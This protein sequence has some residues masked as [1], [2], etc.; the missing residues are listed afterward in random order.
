MVRPLQVASALGDLAAAAIA[1]VL[2][3][4]KHTQSLYI[5]KE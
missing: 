4:G 1:T 2:V 3:D 5:L